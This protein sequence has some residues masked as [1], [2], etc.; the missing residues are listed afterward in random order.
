MLAIYMSV[1]ENEGDREL[2]ERIYLNNRIPMI[3]M[4][5][6]ILKNEMDAEDAVHEVFLQIASKRMSVIKSINNKTDMKNYLIKAVKNTALNMVDKRKRANAIDIDTIRYEDLSVISDKDFTDTVCLR[7]DYDMII[8][9]IR[10]LNRTYSDVLYYHFVLEL[11]F[12]EIAE[13]LNR[14]A[15]TVKVQLSRG[16]KLLLKQ[17][18]I[19]GD[20]NG[21]IQT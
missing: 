20:I 21:D 18:S 15:P 9:S 4:A 13:L 1:I 6:S 2:F 19:G 11:S 7:Y 5:M 8:D 14:K 3:S 16:K 10:K 12:S 17:L